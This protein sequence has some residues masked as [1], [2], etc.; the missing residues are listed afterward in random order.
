MYSVSF[1]SFEESVIVFKNVKG[2]YYEEDCNR[3]L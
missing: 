3:K 2:V 1:N